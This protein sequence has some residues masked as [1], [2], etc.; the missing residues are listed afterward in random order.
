MK[1]FLVFAAPALVAFSNV[2]ATE[3]LFFNGGG[4][5][6]EMLIGYL[7]DPVI[8]QV[9][10]TSPGAKDSIIIPQNQRSRQSTERYASVK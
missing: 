6:I 5:T 7:D 8:A 1:M 10:F 2:R 4:Y 3:V 9:R